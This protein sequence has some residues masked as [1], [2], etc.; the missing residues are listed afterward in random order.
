MQ[1]FAASTSE[2]YVPLAVWQKST[3]VVRSLVFIKQGLADTGMFKNVDRLNS[4]A[5]LIALP[6]LIVYLQK[7]YSYELQL[8]RSTAQRN[9]LE[10]MFI[11]LCQGVVAPQAK[12]EEKRAPQTAT[13]QAVFEE[14]SVPV[15]LVQP[16]AGIAAPVISQSEE[17]WQA[18]MKIVDQLSD[19]LLQSIFKQARFVSYAEKLHEVSVVFDREA[20][21]F[22]DW[23][24]D[25]K[26]TWSGLLETAF[27][28]GVHLK[29]SFGG[30][31][32]EQKQPA[33]APR[34]VVGSTPV[35]LTAQTTSSVQKQETARP[36][37]KPSYKSGSTHQ[38]PAQEMKKEL[39]IDVSDGEKWQKAHLLKELFGGSIVAI[40]EDE[41]HDETGQ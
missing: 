32:Q 24:Q 25:T 12:Q 36:G 31:K 40:Q 7:L 26:A 20:N 29:P 6:D 15:L 18:F 9:V 35:A 34:T 33:S 30:A 17:R 28:S 41:I 27:G 1:L 19:P 10:M 21:F 11:D 2:N 39:A 38:A 37:I 22:T 13:K 23:L 4:F 5:Y 14:R 8:L 16:E 3:E